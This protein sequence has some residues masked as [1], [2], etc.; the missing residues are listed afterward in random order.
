MTV[1]RQT[2]TGKECKLTPD[3]IGKLRSIPSTGTLRKK[4]TATEKKPLQ[5]T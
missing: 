4:F 3:M 2:A 1:I 5:K